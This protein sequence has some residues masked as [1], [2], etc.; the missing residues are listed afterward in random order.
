MMGSANVEIGVEYG[1]V[2]LL[3]REAKCKSGPDLPMNFLF[4]PHNTM[5][6]NGCPCVIVYNRYM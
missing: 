2:E 6:I 1:V 5:K 3:Y 4:S